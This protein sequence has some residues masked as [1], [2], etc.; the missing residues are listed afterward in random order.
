MIG[1][2]TENTMKS[3]TKYSITEEQLCNIFKN[4]NLGQV[5]SVK[6]LDAGEFNS[7]YFV[8][9]NQK[10]YVIKIAPKNIDNVLTYE[11]NLMTR[12]INF[13]N[14]IKRSFSLTQKL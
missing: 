7:A 14:N 1:H 6:S 2:Y 8:N 13:Y 5:T 10:E 9:A 11:H 12:E 3:L 4:A